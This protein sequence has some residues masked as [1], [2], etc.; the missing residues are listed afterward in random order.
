[1]AHYA[2]L[3]VGKTNKKILIF[4]EQLRIVDEVYASIPADESA[5]VH[6][7]RVQDS[8]DWFLGQLPAL[9]ARHDIRAV[10]VTTHGATCVC[11]DETGAPAFPVI[12]YTTDPGQE[13]SDRFYAR[14]G[15]ARALHARLATPDMGALACLGKGI[16]FAQEH[17]GDEF[18]RVADILCLP[19]FFSFLLTGRTGAETTFLGCHTYLWD[20]A[21]A[22]YSDVVDA[23]GIRALMPKPV[24]HPGD[25]LGTVTPEVAA[26]TGLGADVVVTHG[27]HD[28]NASLL[29]F[30]IQND[31][32]FVLN[33]T[34][35][36]CVMMCP[37]D[38]AVLTEAEMDAGAFCNCDANGHP[39]KTAVV[40]AGNEHDQWWR[41]IGERT[42][43]TEIP[44]FDA[45]LVQSVLDAADTFI[46]PG[47]MPG[48]GPFPACESAVQEAGR[49]FSMDDVA[50]GAVPACF[51]SPERAY[52]VLCSA[53]AMLSC[54]QLSAVGTQ[55]G[56][57][58]Y[59]EGGFRKNAAYQALL[60]ALFPHSPIY[61]TDMKEATA[62][63]SAL[64]ARAAVEGCALA[65]LR[66]DF[67]ID[68]TPVNL[69]TLSNAQTYRQAYAK[70]ARRKP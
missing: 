60:A 33:S 32:P 21:A 27:I 20:F 30:L 35:T 57:P 50:S 12:A 24:R 47:V 46:L 31:E 15:E 7:E 42:G 66:T 64:L 41:I 65:D 44:E 17:Y 62:F 3:D 59:I 56:M 45:A 36:W 69:P 40:M 55:D 2:V 13:F 16:A 61:L 11:L 38:G 52:A 37:A 58:I 6:I 28:S 19:Q 26:Q 29:P 8:A 68:A 25:L 18:Q 39:V 53:L 5:P 54:E 10:S 51:D 22:D 49:R 4:D 67:K 23:L 63:G 48:T 1:M 43:A 34:G 9:A 14:C 70:Q